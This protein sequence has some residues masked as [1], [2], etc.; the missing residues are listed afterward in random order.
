MFILKNLMIKII[1]AKWSK[2]I[3]ICESSEAKRM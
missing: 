3:L 2:L 1:E